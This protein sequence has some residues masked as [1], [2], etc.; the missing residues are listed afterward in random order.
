[1]SDRPELLERLRQ[2]LGL[3]SDGASRPVVPRPPHG[4][5]PPPGCEEMDDIPCE[6]AARRVYEFLDGELEEEDAEEIRCHVE[7]CQRCY[8]MYNWEQLFLQAVRER[9]GRPE[10]S[11]E[12]KR[13]VGELLDREAG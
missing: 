6:E 4:N 11:E 8:P 2:L 13:K 5:G 12:L 10:S 9:G 3:G 7:Q 1:M